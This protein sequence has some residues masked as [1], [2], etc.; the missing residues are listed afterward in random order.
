M[1]NHD[2]KKYLLQSC[3]IKRHRPWLNNKNVMEKKTEKSAQKN[4]PK[5]N[6][7]I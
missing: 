3:Q 4:S 1:N 6:Y 7:N 5:K 2:Y